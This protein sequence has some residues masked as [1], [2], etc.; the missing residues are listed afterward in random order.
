AGEHVDI[1][2]DDV[3]RAALGDRRLGDGVVEAAAA[4]ANVENYAT[5]LGRERRRQE[6]PVLHDIGERAADIG[7]AGVG[8]GADIARPKR[9]EDLR[10][11]FGRFHAADVTHDL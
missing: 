7:R 9:V 11:Q 8:V 4:V 2:G 6:L 10:H 1:G 3:G 5:L